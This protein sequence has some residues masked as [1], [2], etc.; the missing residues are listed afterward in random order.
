MM[1]PSDDNPVLIYD[2]ECKLCNKAVRFLEMKPKEA[3]FEFIPSYTDQAVKML[4]A[5]DI[6]PETTRRT[7]ILLDK[8]RIFT[9]STAVIK[10]LIKKGGLWKITALLYIVPARL[11]DAVYDWVASHRNRLL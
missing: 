10:S 2:G 8:G 5:Y 6:S 4:S 1:K 11:R 3:G 9:K 7:L